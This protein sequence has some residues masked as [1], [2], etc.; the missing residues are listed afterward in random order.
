[1]FNPSN[2]DQLRDSPRL[3]AIK[4]IFEAIEAHKPA[5]DV[6]AIAGKIFINL[7]AVERDV[8]P[9]LINKELSRRDNAT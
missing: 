4:L 8:L 3:S 1:M 6:Q 9:G 5:R 2:H 7:N